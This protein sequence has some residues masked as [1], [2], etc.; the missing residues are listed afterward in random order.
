MI[1]VSKLPSAHAEFWVYVDATCLLE[2]VEEEAG[3]SWVSQDT[4]KC[5]SLEISE[6]NKS[7]AFERRSTT[8]KDSAVSVK[9]LWKVPV[10]MEANGRPAV[11]FHGA[12]I[13]RLKSRPSQRLKAE[14]LS[15]RNPKCWSFHSFTFRMM[16]CKEVEVT[17]QIPESGLNKGGI[18]NHE[19]N[20]ER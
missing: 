8:V 9:S 4:T 7:N 15:P 1:I 12:N 5:Q 20:L 6:L 2:Q 16:G 14:G 13:R 17:Q 18:L 19:P 11:C 10:R 3:D